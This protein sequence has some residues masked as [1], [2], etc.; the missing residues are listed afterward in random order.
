MYIL[1][2]IQKGLFL[3][4]GITVVLSACA[5]P[6]KGAFTDQ[7]IC[8]AVVASVMGRNPSIVKVDS[9]KGNITY[10]S[11]VR[12]GDGTHWKYKCMLEGNKAI[13]ATDTGRWRTDQYD[14]KITYSVR[15]RELRISEKYPDGSGGTKKYSIEKLGC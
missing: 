2:K 7:Q 4:A 1:E 8:I 12:S 6:N 15:E 11:Y 10:L 9:V 5:E 13:W 3:V 14:S